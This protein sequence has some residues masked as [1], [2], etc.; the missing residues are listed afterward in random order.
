VWGVGWET[1][2]R[3]RV[4]GGSGSE[5][6]VTRLRCSRFPKTIHLGGG[7]DLVPFL[8][9]LSLPYIYIYIWLALALALAI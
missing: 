5:D 3:E 1:H 6:S 4:Y 2:L 9:S 8:I 7:V